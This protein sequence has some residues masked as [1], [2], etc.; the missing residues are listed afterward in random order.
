MRQHRWPEGALCPVCGSGKACASRLDD[1]TGM[2]LA[3]H[4]QPSRVWVLCLCFMGLNLSNRQIAKELGLDGSG[5]QAMAEQLRRGLA[6]KIP[7]VTLE[8]EVEADEVYVAAGHKGQ[9]KEV[10]KRADRALPQAGRRAGPRH[11]LGNVQ[12]ATIKPIITAAVTLGILVHTDEYSIYA[13]LPTWGYGHKTVCHGRGDTPTTRTADGFCEVHVNTLE[14][15]WPLL[16][17]WL[18]PHRG[19]SQGKLPL[20]LGF[21]QFV[22]NTRRRG[23][24]LLV[25]LIAALAA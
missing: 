12:Q 9:P 19:I 20:Y 7:D 11:M 14:G 17:S 3:G 10:A 15:C 16:R 18:R 8:G 22:H 24:T 25:A 2:V 13:R 4:R 6:A 5:V 1:L 23:R 21:F